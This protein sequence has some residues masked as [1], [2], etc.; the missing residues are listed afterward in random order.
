M[1]RGDG[2][3][4]GGKDGMDRMGGKDGMDRMGGGGGMGAPFDRSQGGRG[5]RGS[6]V[7]GFFMV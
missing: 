7:C 1:K 6:Q 4:M 2:G 3:G 5:E